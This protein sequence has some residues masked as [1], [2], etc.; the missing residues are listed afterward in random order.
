MQYISFITNNALLSSY[1]LKNPNISFDFKLL[2]S[3]TFDI[4]ISARDLIHTGWE[5]LNHPLY[6]NFRQAEQPFRSLLLS[7]TPSKDNHTTYND[8]SLKLIEQAIQW[9]TPFKDKLTII[10]AHIQADTRK[11]AENPDAKSSNYHADCAIL[12][13]ELIR[14]T[15]EVYGIYIS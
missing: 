1:S 2:E 5:L 14:K 6:G 9:Y 13:R 10:D 15:L 12:D 3:S 8:E 4:F 11:I 7:Y